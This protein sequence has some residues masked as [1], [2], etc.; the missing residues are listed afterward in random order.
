MMPKLLKILAPLLL[1]ATPALAQ[2]PTLN[3]G[4]TAWLLTSA[5]LVLLMTIP[6]LGLFYG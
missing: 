6:G 4:D 3:S 1:L 5:A 2:E